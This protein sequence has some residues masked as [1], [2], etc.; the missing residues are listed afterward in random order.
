MKVACFGHQA[1]KIGFPFC[2]FYHIPNLIQKLFQHPS[3]IQLM[4]NISMNFNFN[5][6]IYVDNELNKLAF[7]LRING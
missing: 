7:R 5:Y 2:L 1:Y 4:R 3:I 6:I